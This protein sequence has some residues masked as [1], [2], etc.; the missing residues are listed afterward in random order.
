M[1][2]E[3]TF[4]DVSA[5]E[6]D[7]ALE[8]EGVWRDLPRGGKVKV[9]R[10]QNTE[11]SRLMRTKY[12]AN[13]DLLD[14][15]DELSDKIGQDVMV[16][17]MAVTILKDVSGIGHK[18]KLIQKYTPEIG[19]ELLKVKDFREKI[20]ALSDQMDQYQHKQEAKAVNF[21]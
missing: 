18:G 17:V 19:I 9:A 16:E 6:T 3:Q 8:V 7:P 11:F 4:Y 14:G 5:L 21:S 10:W 2:E 20:K 13:R 12:K 15:E 1:S